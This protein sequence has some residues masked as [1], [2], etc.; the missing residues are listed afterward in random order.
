[1]LEKASTDDV[2]ALHAYTIRSLDQQGSIKTDVEQ[3]K[4]QN[5][6]DSPIESRQRHLDVMCFP[7]LFPS[8][9]FGEFHPRDMHLSCPDMH[10]SCP[11]SPEN[12]SLSIYMVP[13]YPRSTCSHVVQVLSSHT[14]HLYFMYATPPC[15][16]WSIFKF[17]Q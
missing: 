3:Y 15:L 11:H 5:V 13:C 7:T 9:Q 16:D 12:I 4:M 8:G 14:I 17:D 2:A 10:L 6:K 1:M